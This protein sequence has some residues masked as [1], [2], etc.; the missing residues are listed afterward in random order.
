MDIIFCCSWYF[1]D[2]GE[3][4]L[5]K[6]KTWRLN[7]SGSFLT[8][9]WLN[10]FLLNFLMKLKTVKRFGSVFRLLLNSIFNKNL[11]FFKS[12]FF[13]LNFWI[14]IN[15]KNSHTKWPAINKPLFY[16]L[17]NPRHQIQIHH[18]SINIIPFNYKILHF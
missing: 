17:N 8:I 2:A 7:F 12:N 10:V 9:D 5:G 6:R 3:L 15:T 18:T 1:C 4:F 14:Q 16:P 11:K 13:L